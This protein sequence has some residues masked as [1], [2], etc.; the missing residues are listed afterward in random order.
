MSEFHF[1]LDKLDGA[2]ILR[3][4]SED[5]IN[6]LTEACLLSLAE[7]IRQL[8][9]HG[10]ALIITGNAKFFSAGADLKEIEA[11]K[12]PAAFEF[13]RIGQSLMQSVEHFPTPVYAAISGYCMGGGLDWLWR[14][15][16][17]SLRIRHCLG[18]AARP[19]INNRVG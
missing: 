12:G 13:S 8:K 17:V 15:I 6:R 2:W 4:R 1:H 18:I 16:T 11:L 10:Q 14:A 3:L 9:H 19:G 5:G 7:T